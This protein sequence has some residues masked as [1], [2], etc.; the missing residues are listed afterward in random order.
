MKKMTVKKAKKICQLAHMGQTRIDG[1]PYADHPIAVAKM[2]DTDDEK[3]VAYLHDVLEDTSLT[4]K[5]LHKEG[6]NLQ[7]SEAL[8]NITHQQGESYKDYLHRVS[9]SRLS[10][11]VKI[12]DITHNIS[13]TP[14]P[15]Q[16]KKYRK[17]IKILLRS[18]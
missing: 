12:A 5:D 9:F 6:L 7:C 10:V 15:E 11:K 16:V 13:D 4:L 18:L 17:G 1:S 2:M 3:I 14:T 8:F